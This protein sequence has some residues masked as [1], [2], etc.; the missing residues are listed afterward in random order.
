MLLQ[1]NREMSSVRNVAPESVEQISIKIIADCGE[2]TLVKIEVFKLIQLFQYLANILLHRVW[3]SKRW[4]V[5]P[6]PDRCY[7]L[8]SQLVDID[9]F[10]SAIYV[11]AWLLAIAQLVT[12]SC[13]YR[14]IKRLTKRP[15]YVGNDHAGE[16]RACTPGPLSQQLSS[17]CF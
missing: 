15:I 14:I 9:Q 13:Y 11:Y 5:D 8:F 7:K 17:G 4:I 2:D 3:N 1:L 16:R 6:V 10:K 12:K